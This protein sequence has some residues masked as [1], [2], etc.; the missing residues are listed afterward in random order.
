MNQGTLT[1]AVDAADSERFAQ[2]SGDFNPLHVDPVAARR[3]QFGGTVC[4]GIQL[5]LTALDRLAGAGLVDVRRL[6]EVQVVFQSP[7]LTGQEVELGWQATAGGLRLAAR[8]EGRTLFTATLGF[9]EDRPPARAADGP[10]HAPSAPHDRPFESVSTSG[11]TATSGRLDASSPADVAALFPHL[12]RQAPHWQGLAEL[13][14]STRL[15]GMVCP[16]LHS[17]YC[18][19][20]LARRDTQGP[21][22]AGLAWRAAKA[23]PRFRTVRM[24]V[25][26]A[27]WQ[28]SLD[29]LFRHAPVRQATLADVQARVPA[30]RFAGHRALVVGGSRGLGELAAKM[31]LAGGAD[32]TLTYAS[33]RADAEAVVAEARGAG[34][35]C[36]ALPLDVSRTL[37]ALDVQPLMQGAP[38]LVAY[39]ATPLIARG[40]PLQWNAG[41]FERYRRFYVDGLVELVQA[42]VAGAR[43]GEAPLRVLNPSS[44]FVAEPVKG[45]AEYAAAKAASEVA[46]THLALTGRAQVHSPRLARLRTDQNSDAA[47]PSVADPFPALDNALQALLGTA[48]R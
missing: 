22:G 38:T 35:P 17:V 6:D 24:E 18:G 4:H 41:L 7:V 48:S 42:L 34:L 37:Q 2:L 47:D 20:K 39:F 9:G 28:G 32:V 45:F 16:G 13:M 26:G 25:S 31:L 11:D 23:D 46:A 12:H 33:G 21:D 15:V 44:V 27:A 30:G 3:L 29:T 5:L 43:P 36:R 19:L 14:A 1:F 40:Q 10:G 8:R